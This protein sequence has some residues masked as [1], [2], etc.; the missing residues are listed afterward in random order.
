MSDKKPK[1]KEKKLTAKEQSDLDALKK[2]ILHGTT[3]R[4]HMCL[5]LIE[6]FKKGKTRANFCAKHL[7][8]STTFEKWVKKHSLFAAS[9]AI[10]HECARQYYDDLRQDYMVEEFEGAKINW[11][12]FNKMYSAR[13]NIADKRAVK[14]KG[15]GTSK[16]EREMVNCLTKAIEEGELTPDEATKL[17]S[18]VDVSLR[19]KTTQEL[20]ARVQELE[21]S[22]ELGI[23]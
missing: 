7:I 6:M 22:Q 13:F 23:K 5:E 2:S 19:V 14:I 11:G 9:Y 18:I 17:A 12:L 15:L 1:K 8:S 4:E 20:E 10:A 3:Y 21:K 16:D